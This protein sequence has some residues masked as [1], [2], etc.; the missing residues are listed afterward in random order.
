MIWCFLIQI[1]G[2][3]TGR[4]R[5]Q[6]RRLQWYHIIMMQRQC[7]SIWTV[8]VGIGQSGCPV[9]K[10]EPSI[11]LIWF[12]PDNRCWDW[13][14][15]MPSK[16]A[17]M[18]LWWYKIAFQ[19]R[20]SVWCWSDDDML[21]MTTGVLTVHKSKSWVLAPSVSSEQGIGN[22]DNHKWNQC[23]QPDLDRR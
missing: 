20:Q 19:S 8:G 18:I 7:S 9:P 3:A 11:M 13:W 22:G 6:V 4:S 14:I 21:M 5:C 2:V 15:R 17:A 12:N 1:I 16:K 23:G 10:L